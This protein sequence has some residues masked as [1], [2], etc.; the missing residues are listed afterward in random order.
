MGESHTSRVD[1]MSGSIFKKEMIGKS[2]KFIKQF[3]GRKRR[4]FLKNPNNID[5]I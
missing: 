3:Y 4:M 1:K 5:K 2:K